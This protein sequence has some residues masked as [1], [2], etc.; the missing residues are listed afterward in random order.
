[1]S[2]GFDGP[3]ERIIGKTA[4]GDK[5]LTKHN[6]GQR[7]LLELLNMGSLAFMRHKN[8]F[9]CTRCIDNPYL[10]KHFISDP[11]PDIF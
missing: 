7:D 3:I 5:L 10:S 11:K 2:V 4:I 1:M 8:H 9:K 6:N